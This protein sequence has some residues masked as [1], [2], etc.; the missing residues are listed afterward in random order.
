MGEPFGMAGIVRLR[1]FC[2]LT[3]EQPVGLAGDLVRRDGGNRWVTL[4]GCV[5]RGQAAL[6]M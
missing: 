6:A 5:R 2:P 1:D 4:V 3:D